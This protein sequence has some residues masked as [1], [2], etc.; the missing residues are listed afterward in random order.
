MMQ[1]RKPKGA[2]NGTGGQYTTHPTDPTGLPHLDQHTGKRTPKWNDRALERT[3]LYHPDSLTRGRA[4]HETHHP[5]GRVPH[6]VGRW[7]TP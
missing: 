5:R 2:P 3:A 1:P 4:W 6:H 7:A